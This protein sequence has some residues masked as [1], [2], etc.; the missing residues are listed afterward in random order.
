MDLGKVIRQ[1]RIENGYTQ[2]ELGKLI[3]V[4]K[5]AIHKYESGIVQNMKRTTIGK[6][7]NIFNVSPSYLL[8]YTTERE[9]EATT[10]EQQKLLSLIDQLTEEEVVELSNYVDFIISK[11]KN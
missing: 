6:L 8:G 7:A 3:G 10:E 11:R 4:K 5:A 9:L 1:L 2:E